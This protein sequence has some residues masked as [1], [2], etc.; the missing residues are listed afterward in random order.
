MMRKADAGLGFL[1]VVAIV[2]TL[3]AGP[4]AAQAVRGTVVDDRNLSRVATATVRLLQGEEEGPATE[5]DN[6]GHFFLPLPGAG[7][8]R[9]QV[10][11][12]GYLTT[13][14]QTFRVEKDDTVTVEFRVAPNALLMAP[15]TVTARS[16]SG[17]N[18]FNRH[19]D[20]WGKGV[21]LTPEQLAGMSLYSPA[22]VFRG[23]DGIHLTWNWGKRGDGFRGPIASV[24]SRRAECLLYMVNRVFVDPPP[25]AVDIYQRKILSSPQAEAAMMN[26]RIW[27][28]YEI[29]GIPPSSIAGVEVYRSY[30]EVPPDLRR[31]THKFPLT[32][33][34]LVVYWTKG[35]W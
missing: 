5:T 29:A 22:D 8:Y 7:T 34:G 10:A 33:C 4:A 13:R 17:R 35:A 6:Q 28:S 16:K 26:R 3:A 14:S 21:F 31:Y 32:N 1:I 20:E 2:S 27:S 30:S 23:V 15:I 9:L 12:L 25:T 24:Q 19:K 11:R 18:A